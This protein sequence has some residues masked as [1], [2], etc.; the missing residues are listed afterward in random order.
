MAYLSGTD[1]GNGLAVSPVLNLYAGMMTDSTVVNILMALS[2]FL[3]PFI[4]LFAMATVCTRNLFA[5]SFDR[6]FPSFVAKVHPRFSS[7]WVATLLIIIA[8]ES[9]LA[10]YVF[11]TIF[12]NITNYTAIFSIAFWMASW[13]AILLPYRRPDLFR[14]APANVRRRIGGV[15]VITL[16]GIGNL[17]LFSLSLW[18]VFKY[19]A[20]TGP[21]GSDAV[22]FIVGIY[23][24]GIIIYLLAKAIQ[25]ARGVDLNLLYR[26]IPPE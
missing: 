26:E 23:V 22:L 12:Q 15:P 1:E 3:W 4:L 21:T 10:V 5:W 14:G 17:A 13:A 25:K 9:L 8:I 24:G 20:F 18:G 7:P 11:T 6:V 16:V 2:F 19:P